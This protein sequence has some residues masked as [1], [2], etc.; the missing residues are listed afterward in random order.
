MLFV[1]LNHV[2]INTTI[3]QSFQLKVSL[4]SS[5]LTVQ[6]AYN[7][8]PN[9]TINVIDRSLLIGNPEAKQPVINYL[10]HNSIQLRLQCNTPATIYWGVGIYPTMLG[11]TV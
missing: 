7:A 4:N 10:T 2:F 8:I 3:G 5:N 1:V 11:I 6:N 9:I